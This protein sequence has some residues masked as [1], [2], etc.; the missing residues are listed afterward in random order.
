MLYE[1]KHG[2]KALY[3]VLLWANVRSGS[4]K[5]YCWW[6][7]SLQRNLLSR[8]LLLVYVGRAASAVLFACRVISIY[9]YCCLPV[10]FLVSF[11]A[12]DVQQSNATM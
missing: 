5:K 10:S 8:A 9:S 7:G 2:A 6:C 4:S 11:L 12:W 1:V 3:G